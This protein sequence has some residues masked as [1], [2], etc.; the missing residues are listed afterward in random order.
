FDDKG[1]NAE[2][3]H[4]P[5]PASDSR[6]DTAL[7]HLMSQ[8]FNR[9]RCRGALPREAVDLTVQLLQ[10]G[11]TILL[12]GLHLLF[13]PADLKAQGGGSGLAL[14]LLFPGMQIVERGNV[15]TFL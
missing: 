8:S 9:L 1:A 11:G 13:A 5:K 10:A 14:L 3:G 4:F 2:I 15:S 7:I 12:P 6:S